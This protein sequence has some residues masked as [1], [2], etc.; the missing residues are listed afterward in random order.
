MSLILDIFS[1]YQP[2]DVQ[3]TAYAA[4]LSAVGNTGPSASRPASSTN[5]S[6]DR[7]HQQVAT[8]RLADPGQPV[9]TSGR[10][11]LS[12][13][14]RIQSPILN[15]TKPQQ[16]RAQPEDS[17]PVPPSPPVKLAGMRTSYSELKHGGRQEE[18]IEANTV[19]RAAQQAS[20][21]RKNLADPK[22]NNFVGAPQVKPPSASMIGRD[23]VPESLRNTLDHIVSQLD[24]ITKTMTILEQ[25]L[26]VTEDR[27]SSV[28]SF[29]RDLAAKQAQAQQQKRESSPVV[30][31]TA[32]T[33][34]TGQ[35]P[36][37]NLHA[38]NHGG[39][40][41]APRQNNQRHHL[42]TDSLSS[43]GPIN[44]AVQ[45]TSPLVSASSTIHRINNINAD[46]ESR[47][48][49]AEA[50]NLTHQ[51][52][53]TSSSAT[54]EQVD[55]EERFEDDEGD[56]DDPIVIVGNYDSD[57]EEDDQHHRSSSFN[58]SRSHLDHDDTSDN[59]VRTNN[60]VHYSHN[61]S[62]SAIAMNAANAANE[63]EGDDDDDYTQEYDTYNESDKE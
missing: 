58:N 56:D 39:G 50:F 17:S 24:V 60:N 27:V 22:I 10:S 46:N 12:G 42:Q 2:I 9:L 15:R 57:S 34:R 63:D 41:N 6:V 53:R 61:S 38:S 48:L 47:Q 13:S 32:T 29:T 21:P 11:S 55:N 16:Y 31:S 4:S 8:K 59:M 23:E 3:A 33:A 20:P 37:E 49:L 45:P 18:N 43:R 14:L 54:A 1:V 19:N 51:Q 36:T 52:Q 25:R 62:S 35:S 26:T 5:S 7:V 30:S 28:I 44:I 40:T